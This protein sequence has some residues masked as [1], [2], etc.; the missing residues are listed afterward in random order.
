MKKNWLLK[1]LSLVL[2]GTMMLGIAGCGNTDDNK[3]VEKSTDTEVSGSSEIG[4]STAV[5]GENQKEDEFVLSYPLDTDIAFSFFVAD[6][7]VPPD[8]NFDKSLWHQGLEEAT[9]IKVEWQ[10]QPGD[11]YTN[12]DLT[13]A[14]KEDRP[15]AFTRAIWD[16][17]TETQWIVDDVIVDLTDYLPIYAPD[18][19]EYLH[20]EGNESTLKAVTDDEGRF[21]YVPGLRESLATTNYTGP[22]I[23]QDWLKECGLD[24]PITM[25][26]WEKVLVAF[27][28]KYGAKFVTRLGAFKSNGLAS[29]TGAMG[30]L[31]GG[32]YLDDGK[33][34]LAN[35]QPEWKEYISY[36]AKWYDMGLI[37]EDMFAG[38][39]AM[40]RQKALNGETGIIFNSQSQL[41]LYCQDADANNTGAEWVGLSYPRTEAG[42]PTS[43]IQVG[44]DTTYSQRA[45]ISTT[46]DK[47]KIPTI[48]AWLNYPYTEE[49]MLYYNYG[50]EGVS[51]TLDA[52]G[53]PQWTDLVLNDPNGRDEGIKKWSAM[54]GTCIGV[55]LVSFVESRNIPVAVEAAR[56]WFENTEA[57]KYMLPTLSLTEDETLVYADTWNACSTYIEECAIAFMTGEKSLDEFDAYVQEL[58]KLGLQDII[59]IQQAAYDR[60]V[61][62]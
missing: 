22:V 11:T 4:T 7:L 32:F 36:L 24:M 29:G 26:D 3:S 8:H 2:A 28:E 16:N 9:G 31:A 58:N 59:S 47:E 57:P 19:W 56:T 46:C 30:G 25:E 53:T 43:C 13:L 50:Q 34:K 14:V 42:A 17:T 44:V 37:D 38:D 41:T 21:W 5:S 18:L 48:L 60:Y 20:K 51:Y 1:S 10:F 15:D 12:L 33:V 52:N 40:L 62:K 54:T 27:N 35:I 45:Y 49:G 23:R 6:T 61:S 39:N 55:Q